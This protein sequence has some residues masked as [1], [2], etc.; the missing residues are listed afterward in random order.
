MNNKIKNILKKF[1]ENGFEAYIVGGFVRDYLLGQCSYD[2][3]ISTNATPKEVKEIFNLTNSNDENYGHIYFKDSLYNYD[4]TTFRREIKYENRKPVEFEYIDNIEEDIFRRDFTINSLYMDIDGNIHDIVGG[5]KDLEDGIIRT[6]GNISEKMIEDPLRILRAVRFASLL[7]F[8]IEPTLYNYIR[9]NKQLIRTLSYTRK[10]EELD[11]IFKNQNKL[12][13]IEL[14]KA[15]NIQ[16]ELEIEIPDDLSYSENPLGTWAQVTVSDN[17]TF[18]KADEEKI[19]DIRK[20]INYGIIDSIVLYEYG[21]YSC[22]IAGEI[23]GEA[24]SNISD[25]YKNLP[26]YSQKDIKINGDDII[27]ILNIEPGEQ[28]KQILFD[29]EIMILNNSLANDYE[30]LKNYIIDTWR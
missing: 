7:N 9:Q 28:I 24:R 14:I 15:L 27:E 4:I 19:N 26:I 16:N 2:I 13:G 25:L 21:L 6:V 17:Y 30:T 1:I 10:K 8:E 12:K 3:D 29:I 11:K 5:K 23:L 20:I 18:K 22:I